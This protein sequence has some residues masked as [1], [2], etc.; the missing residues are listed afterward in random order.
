MSRALSMLF[1]HIRECVRILSAASGDT[2][3][4]GAHE[5]YR[6]AQRTARCT[7]RTSRATT[8]ASAAAAAA[9][10]VDADRHDK[11]SATTVAASIAAT[12]VFNNNNNDAFNFC[13]VDSDS[14]N[15]NSSNDNRYNRQKT[16][17]GIDRCEMKQ[18]YIVQSQVN[19][20][21]RN[22]FV[23]YISFFALV[24]LF[25]KIRMRSSKLLI[26]RHGLYEQRV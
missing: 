21:C 9:V 4:A 15:T 24:R 13:I 10:D 16:T 3:R 23:I 18:S 7:A 17:C 8:S 26:F 20:V 19:A 14:N 2:T 1:V 25:Q 6:A 11:R 5:R 12:I 22:K